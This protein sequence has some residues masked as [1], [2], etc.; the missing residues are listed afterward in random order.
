ME[1]KTLTPKYKTYKQ[2][3]PVM[4]TNHLVNKSI[5][6]IGDDFKLTEHTKLLYSI[7]VEYV[8]KSPGFEKRVLKTSKKDIPFSFKKG[9][10]FISRPGTGK[11]FILE[12]LL[13]AFS[14]YFPVLKYKQMTAYDIED[15]YSEF[16]LLASK[17]I[18]ANHLYIDDF[19][20]EAVKIK[21]FGTDIVF[22]DRF[23]DMRVR[24]LKTYGHLTHGTSNLSLAEMKQRYSPPTF[25]RMFKLFN[26]IVFDAKDDFR[27]S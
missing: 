11:S 12:D 4:T 16:G 9:L 22:F 21:H 25:S 20:R 15:L 6:L 24:Q 1:T 19:G 3:R 8:N 7:V 26:F 18:Q 13:R 17:K 23:L 5:E 14:S 27:I 10:F 2:T